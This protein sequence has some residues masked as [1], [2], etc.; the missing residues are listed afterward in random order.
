MLKK[1]LVVIVMSMIICVVV[2]NEIVLASTSETE[3][4]RGMI[5]LS[6]DS[7]LLPNW[8][9]VSQ[10]LVSINHGG[11]NISASLSILPINSGT[12]TIGTF[13]IEEYSNGSWKRVAYWHINTTGTVSMTGNYTGK[14]GRSYRA[15]VIVTSGLDNIDK[16]SSQITL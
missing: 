10:V 9:S 1:S 14:S 12:T 15:R 3:G 5:S 8:S 16:K 6:A 7:V 11:N 2:Q 4:E 13:R